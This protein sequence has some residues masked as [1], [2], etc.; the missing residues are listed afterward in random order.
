[1]QVDGVPAQVR[2]LG[3]MIL[4]YAE[5]VDD[6]GALSATMGRVSQQH[7]SRA[8][9]PGQYEAIGDCMIFAMREVLGDAADPEFVQAWTEA[10]GRLAEML[11]GMEKRMG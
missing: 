9:V 1:M 4:S 6:L 2:A 7:V 5:H 8:V 3:D 10:Y 11:K